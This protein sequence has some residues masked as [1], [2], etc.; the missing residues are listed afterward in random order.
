MWYCKHDKIPENIDSEKG[1]KCKYKILDDAEYLQELNEK[2]LEETNISKVYPHKF[3]RTMTTMAIDKGMPV[4]QVQELLG[5]IKIDT[6]MHYAMVSQNNV[7][8]S[9]R[10]Y[11]G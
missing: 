10:K 6:T 3:R 7:K 8:I 1:R 9:H 4:E 11:I 2:I 5:H